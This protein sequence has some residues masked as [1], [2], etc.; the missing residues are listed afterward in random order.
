MKKRVSDNKILIVCGIFFFYS[1]I[2]FSL[3][4]QH[5]LIQADT[6]SYVNAAN[7]I[8]KSGFFSQDGIAPDY[9]R[10]PGYPIFL[11]IIY[12]LGGNNTV[13]AIVQIVLSTVGIYLIYKT[14]LLLKTPKNLALTGTALLI[15]DLTLQEYAS[16]ILTESLFA[17]FLVS[18]LYF[19][20][21][22]IVSGRQSFSCFLAF[23][24]SLNYA[25]LIRPIL[26]YF[27]L[28][29]TV[30]LFIFFILKKVQ[31]KQAAAF[32]LC[33]AVVF[34]GWSY[35]NYRYSSVFV[36]SIVRNYNLMY[37][38]STV[39]KARI[40]KISFGDAWENHQTLFDLEYPNAANSGMNSA[41]L[42]VLHGEYGSRYIKNHF[43]QFLLQ[44]VVGL[45]KVM[46]GPGQTFIDTIFPNNIIAFL[47][48]V[49]YTCYLAAIYML[50]LNGAIMNYRKFD[51]VQVFIFL[52]S[53]YLAI[54]SASVGYNRFRD[55]FFRLILLGAVSNSS[56]ILERVSAVLNIRVV[57]KVKDWLLK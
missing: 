50:Y 27:N 8:L 15:F 56:V 33:F 31:L 39:L 35:R 3:F 47:I 53:A 29:V 30:A 22:F 23:T 57:T 48:K 55:P 25:L 46:L 18:S 11:A 19:F 36:Y 41:Q 20:V 6:A 10:T 4:Q 7:N 13:V 14:L 37:F 42:S 49:I 44:N 45:Y 12:M 1:I 54:A 26:M 51:I 24:I 2:F 9:F 38:D 43:P 52:L 16:I 32:F 28:L 34:I 5:T 17:F 40:E 21:K